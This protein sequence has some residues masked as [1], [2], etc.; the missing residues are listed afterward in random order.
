MRW[1]S[2][3][4]LYETGERVELIYD[5]IRRRHLRPVAFAN[6]ELY[7]RCNIAIRL[8]NGH[9]VVDDCIE[10]GLNGRT[11]RNEDEW[12][13]V[14]GLEEDVETIEDLFGGRS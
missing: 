1:R 7:S 8:P 11:F 9:I 14:V 12:R 3:G 13:K 4:D 10:S 2:V 5:K 6:T